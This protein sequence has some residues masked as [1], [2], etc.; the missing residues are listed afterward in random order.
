MESV[1]YTFN[2]V[3]ILGLS[4]IDDKTKLEKGDNV[5]AIEMLKNK[6]GKFDEYFIAWLKGYF[7]CLKMATE[8]E[9]QNL[10]KRAFEFDEE[11]FK[12]RK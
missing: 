12:S 8:E 9:R 5:I 2:C 6:Y 11:F 1:K 3:V 4:L 7:G 10:C